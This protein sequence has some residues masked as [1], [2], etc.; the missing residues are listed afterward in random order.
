MNSEIKAKISA[1]TKATYA[2][3]LAEG[4]VMPKANDMA[5]SH[6]K[7]RVAWERKNAAGYKHPNPEASRA[8]LVKAHAAL[9]GKP[10]AAAQRVAIGDALRGRK[11]PPEYVEKNRLGHIG[12]PCSE[13]AKEAVRKRGRSPENLAHLQRIYDKNKHISRLNIALYKMLRESEIEFEAEYPVGGYHVDAYAPNT[14]TAYEADGFYWHRRTDA[15]IARD[16]N[17]DRY[18][19]SRGFVADVVRLT[20]DDLN[21]WTSK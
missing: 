5:A 15:Q 19:I 7:I 9:R 8:N 16:N 4:Y 2:K 17:R 18:L 13:N 6:A 3:K 10:M 11:Q 20:E 14:S 12:I 21:P 1:S